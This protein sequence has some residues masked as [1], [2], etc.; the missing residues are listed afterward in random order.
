[1]NILLTASRNL[2]FQGFHFINCFA[3]CAELSRPAPI[4]WASKKLLKSWA[5]GAKVGRKGAKP[6][7]KLT[8]GLTKLSR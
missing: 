5:Q 6:F 8:P 4:I 3:P 7:M 2:T 1:M